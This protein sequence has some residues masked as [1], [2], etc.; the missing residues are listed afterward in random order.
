MVAAIAE[1]PFTVAN[2]PVSSWN[3]AIRIWLA[4][5]LALFVSFW[6]QLKLRRQLR[7]PLEILPNG[8]GVKRWTRQV[9]DCSPP[10]WA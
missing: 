1:Q 5:I 8:P 7:L 2:T 9:F 10:S 4:T 3:F 6:L